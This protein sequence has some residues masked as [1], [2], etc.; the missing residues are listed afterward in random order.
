MEALQL[1]GGRQAGR[2]GHRAGGKA[3]RAELALERG[4]AVLTEGVAL[5][6]AVAPERLVGDDQDTGLRARRGSIHLESSLQHDAEIHAEIHPEIQ[7]N[8]RLQKRRESAWPST[9]SP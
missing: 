4:E 9:S 8:A 2:A 1:G 7:D 5:G 3:L 6:E